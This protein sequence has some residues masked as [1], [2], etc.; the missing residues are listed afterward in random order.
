MKKDFF[1][2][3]NVYG[4]I[5]LSYDGLLLVI[6]TL[7][8]LTQSRD[9]DKTSIN[10]KIK[11]TIYV[12]CSMNRFDLKSKDGDIFIFVIMEYLVN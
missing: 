7:V 3:N 4:N 11:S 12:P 1:W 9:E 2:L 5:S 10:Q 8:F 6:R